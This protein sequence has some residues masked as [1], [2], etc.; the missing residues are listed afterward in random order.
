LN[1]VSNETNENNEANDRPMRPIFDRQQSASA[2]D[3]TNDNEI[4]IAINRFEINENRRWENMIRPYIIMNNDCETVTFIGI[5]LDRT[6][7]ALMN[8]NTAKPLNDPNTKLPII[9]VGLFREIL[10]QKLPIFENF[11]RQ[12]ASSKTR[13][14]QNVM[15]I[16]VR[17]NIKINP[18]P[19]YELTMDNCLKMMSI[20]LR[21][22]CNIPVVSV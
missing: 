1:T 3:F 16:N 7:K 17:N 13:T 14:L 11:N 5:Y 2:F 18:D 8:P 21:F 15:G 19:A 10:N 6:T 12:D 4:H 20:F 9:D 22:S